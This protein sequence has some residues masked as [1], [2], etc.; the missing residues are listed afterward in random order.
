MVRSVVISAVLATFLIGCLSLGPAASTLPSGLPSFGITTPA[1]PS[2]ATTTPTALAMATLVAPSPSTEAPSE[3]PT[4]VTPEAPG[5]PG[6]TSGLIEDFGANELLFSDDFSDPTS[7][8]GVGPNAAGVTAYVDGALQMDTLS[9]GYWMWSSRMHAL[10]WPVM[11]VEAS[12]TPSASGY[13][14]LFCRRGDRDFWGGRI[15]ADGTWSFARLDGEGA[16][17]LASQAGWAI[18]P[19]ATTRLAL[20]CA[21]TETGS[22]RLQLSLPDLGLAASYEG[23]EGEERFDVAAVYTRSDAHPY[24]VRIDDAVV[25]GGEGETSMSPEAQALLMHVPADW[26]PDCIQ[27]SCSKPVGRQ[28][29]PAASQ[30]GAQTSSTTFSSTARRTWTRPTRLGR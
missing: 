9:E 20:D 17:T 2:A 7:G 8:W 10:A 11:H 3:E 1:P 15:N 26:R 19:G 27:T 24:S 4:F 6:A 14:G 22:L 18:A 13:L 23:S 21:G 16:H 30:R 28:R 12:F 5:T 29:S 25:Y